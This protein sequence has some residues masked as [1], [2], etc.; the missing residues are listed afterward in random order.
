MRKF[1]YI[2][3]LSLIINGAFHLWSQESPRARPS[4]S[5]EVNLSSFEKLVSGPSENLH[6][7]V[8]LNNLSQPLNGSFHF[9]FIINGLNK[10]KHHSFDSAL[11]LGKDTV[12]SHSISFLPVDTACT[13]C[14]AVLYYRD[15]DV[16]MR[17]DGLE[18]AIL[19]SRYNLVAMHKREKVVEKKV[20]VRPENNNILLLEY[21]L[22]DNWQHIIKT[23]LASLARMDDKAPL[24]L[25]LLALFFII[26]GSLI[27][28]R[29][30]ALDK[31]RRRWQEIKGE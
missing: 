4:I 3:S 27:I 5:L 1:R 23:W 18:S 28:A 2:L 19:P 22:E 12:Y 11:S 21:S 8:F 24:F 25:I 16:M 13:G 29:P 31:L 9:A 7:E 20:E 26:L 30:G 15:A 17:V 10:L 6:L 14:R